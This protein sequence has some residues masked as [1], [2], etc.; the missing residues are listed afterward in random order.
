M[1]LGIDPPT[2]VIEKSV[3]KGLEPQSQTVIIFT[4]PFDYTAENRVGMRA[5]ASV[6]DIRLREIL[7]ED[8]GGTYGVQ[9]NGGYEKYPD[10]EYTFSIVFG[11]DPD[12]VDE[13]VGVVF[14]EIERLKAE[15]P[16]AEDV[17]KVKEAERRSRETNLEENRWWVAQLALTDEYGTDPRLLLDPTFLDTVTVESV[18]ERAQRYLRT[19]NFVRVSLFPETE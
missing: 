11:S 4:G 10:S 7:R 12:R 13:L 14:Q 2:G 8:L 9:V 16:T 17:D 6:L 19:G 5:L 15:G 3:R 18:Q 1:D